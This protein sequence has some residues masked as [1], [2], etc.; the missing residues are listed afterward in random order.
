MNEK[1]LELYRKYP[2]FSFI[3]LDTILTTGEQKDILYWYYIDKGELPTDV[4]MIDSDFATTTEFE[5]I[6]TH[7]IAEEEWGRF[8]DEVWKS[9]R[10]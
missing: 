5:I 1:M 10:G 9:L 4:P 6:P 8:E 7:H 3:K 2:G